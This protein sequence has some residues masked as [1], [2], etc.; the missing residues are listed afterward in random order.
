MILDIYFFGDLRVRS[1]INLHFQVLRRTHGKARAGHEVMF[2]RNLKGLN[3]EK[4][5]SAK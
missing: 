1:K 2:Y 5:L 4:N 3:Y